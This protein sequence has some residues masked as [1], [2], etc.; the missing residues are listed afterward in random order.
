MATSFW[1]TCQQ[2]FSQNLPV[3]FSKLK[4][5]FFF[6]NCNSHM[7]KLFYIFLFLVFPK[8]DL[9]PKNTTVLVGKSL[10]IHCNATGSPKPKISWGREK[11]GGDKLDKEHFTQHS[12]G[13]L[14]IKEVR[15]TDSGKYYCIAGN[16]ADFKQITITLKVTGGYSSFYIASFFLVRSLV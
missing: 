8:F 1:V 9:E 10:W 4:F 6:V 14:Y 11:V 12:N 7:N 16:A 3:F 15:P 5:L 2:N 13:T